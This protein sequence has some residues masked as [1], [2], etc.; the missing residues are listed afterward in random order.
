MNIINI[1]ETFL[2]IFEVNIYKK[3]SNLNIS[4]TQYPDL[5]PGLYYEYKSCDEVRINIL[6]NKDDEKCE[7]LLG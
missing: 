5:E 7:T 2:S 1:I 4:D 6:Y 3:F